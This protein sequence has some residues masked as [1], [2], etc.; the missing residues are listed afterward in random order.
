MNEIM[1]FVVQ[2]VTGVKQEPEL[3]IFV[4]IRAEIKLFE[5]GNRIG[6]KKIRFRSLPG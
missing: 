4:K 6:V 2:T 1:I 5:S 3:N